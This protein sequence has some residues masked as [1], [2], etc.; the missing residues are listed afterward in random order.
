MTNDVEFLNI[1]IICYHFVRMAEGYLFQPVGLS[2][3]TVRFEHV[4][5]G[6]NLL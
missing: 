5:E 6:Y 3:R 2:L 4:H 1:C